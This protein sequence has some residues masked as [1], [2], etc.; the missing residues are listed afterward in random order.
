MWPVGRM[1]PTPV[2]GGYGMSIQLTLKIVMV[3]ES[4]TGILRAAYMV[5]MMFK[6]SL[7]T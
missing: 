7:P 6:M 4:Q 2:I 3:Q 5:S 1:L